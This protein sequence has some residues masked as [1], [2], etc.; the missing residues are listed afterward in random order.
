VTGPNAEGGPLPPV[1]PELLAEHE[2][3]IAEWR[4][5]RRTNEDEVRQRIRDRIGEL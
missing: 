4:E 1:D 3:R 5:E 2:R